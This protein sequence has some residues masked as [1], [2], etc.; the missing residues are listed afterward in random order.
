MTLKKIAT[1]CLI[2]FN[3]FACHAA[4]PELKLYLDG[5][6]SV[7][8]N[9]IIH[10]QEIYRQLEGS[11]FQSLLEY[12]YLNNNLN[13]LSSEQLND[14]INQYPQSPMAI[15]LKRS[16]LDKL[17]VEQRYGDYVANYSDVNKLKYQCQY[18][19]A[20]NKL[21]DL[22]KMVK[23]AGTLFNNGQPLP[24][25]C[26]QV[27]ANYLT[28]LPLESNQ[29]WQ[30]FEQA[31][32][33][34]NFKLANKLASMMNA[35]DSQKAQ[36]MLLLHNKPLKVSSLINKQITTD[37]NVLSYGLYRLARI[38]PDQAHKLYQKTNHRAWPAQHKQR[39]LQAIALK[40]TLMKNN[41]AILF[42]RKL[43]GFDLPSVY[44]AYLF[45]AAI[46]FKA[47]PL[48]METIKAF[49]QAKQAKAKYQ[50]WFAYALSQ[51]GQ[52][53]RANIIYRQL[54]KHDN[55]YGFLARYKLNR[56]V[57][58]N[59]KG[60]EIASKVDLKVEK[61]AGFQRAKQFYAANMKHQARVELYYLFKHQP[62][63]IKH[64]IAQRVQQ[65]G[66]HSQALRLTY[67]LKDKTDWPLRYP[68]KY[69]QQI[70]QH[71]KAY[72]VKQPLIYSI[73]RQES[74][75]TENIKSHAGA[76]GLMQ[77]MPKTAWRTAKLHKISYQSASSLKKAKTNLHLGIAHLHDLNKALNKHPLLVIAA[78]NAGKKAVKR[79]LPRH[80]DSMTGELWIEMVPYKET[81]RYLR[82]VV[83]NYVIYQ[84][85]LGKPS[86]LSEIL[87][88]ISFRKVP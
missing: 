48:M 40:Y 33:K 58:I 49:P 29:S 67:K 42:Y 59:L 69:H 22:E 10:Y 45:K 80:G 57:K 44:Q 41:K 84:N 4:S 62:S 72:D 1:L 35:I 78:Y 11:A 27:Y 68:L 39:V 38:R 88:P 25:A 52:T 2:F 65:W 66:W 83:T 76:I 37:S 70:K 82:H 7:K 26:E 86:D 55:Y 87:S 53:K 30:R 75:F 43:I 51:S 64:R 21:A 46:Y 34:R 47:W 85:H 15:W 16:W 81:R 77:L 9:N 36:R 54:A 12:Q 24:E 79:W 13:Q 20:L 61:L 60:K 17:Y 31:L 73:I 3:A 14:Y 5:K 71:A 8:D 50:F 74:L 18:L 63:I 23:E 32:L 6:Q 28:M 19:Y 56:S